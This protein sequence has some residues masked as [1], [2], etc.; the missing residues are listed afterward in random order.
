MNTRRLLLTVLLALTTLTLAKVLAE[1]NPASAQVQRLVERGDGVL[2]YRWVDGPN[3][4]EI[5]IKGDVLFTDDDTGIRSISRGGF[6]RI[7]E[8]NRSEDHRL[9]IEPGDDGQL[10]YA[11]YLNGRRHAFDVAA[12]DWL[13]QMLPRVIRNT[14]IGAEGRV[15]R[16]L[17]TGGVDAVLAEI[18][19]IE[20]GS[21]KVA[22][23]SHLLEKGRLQPRD[24]ERLARDVLASVPSSGDKAR[25]LTTAADDYLAVPST[26]EAY[27]EAIGSIPS[28]GEHTRVLLHLLDHTDLSISLLER[29]LDSAR[30]IASSGDKARVLTEAAPRYVGEPAVRTAYFD[31]VGRIPSSG[32]HMRVLLTLLESADPLDEAT[33]E[34]IFTSARQIASSGDKARLLTAVAPHYART[35]AHRR[36]YFEAVGSIPSS[37]DHAGVLLALLEHPQLDRATLE[38]LLGSVREIASSGDKARVLIAAAPRVAGDDALVDAYLATAETIPSSNDRSRALTALLDAE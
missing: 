16:L 21:A 20:S 24:L 31:A 38:A 6:L 7:E 27:F 26:H 36:A 28:S 14:G 30:G 18:D 29:I 15:E 10:T 3:S 34:A 33:I 35:P 11:Y 9:E 12:K 8:R 1:L 13:A 4:L 22:Y 32:D 25:L 37:G 17:K 2:H 5:D 23:A 19:R